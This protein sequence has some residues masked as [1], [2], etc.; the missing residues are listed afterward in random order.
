M[1]VGVVALA[2]GLTTLTHPAAADD[3]DDL[4]LDEL[5]D[6][7]EELEEEYDGEVPEFTNAKEEAEA[8]QEELDQV[9]EDLE[10]ARQRVSQLAAAQYRGSGLDPTMEL[11]VSSDPENVLEDA[12]VVGHM[13]HRESGLVLNLVDAK[14]E[15]EDAADTA[16]EALSA[17]E[18][19]IEDLESRRDEVAERIEELEAE[20]LPSGGGDGT[21]PE[22]VKGWGWDGATPRM[23]AARDEIIMELGT[24]YDVG[25]L[26]PGD[27]GDHG[28]GNACDW[29]M[30]VGGTMPTDENLAWG[31]AIADYAIENAD[32]L[33]IKYVIWKQRIY[34]T[35]TSGGW[36]QMGDRGSITENHWDHPHISVF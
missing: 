22:S 10:A 29:M 17:A 12:S 33:G 13:A 31:D 16:A 2:L 34:D 24:P 11:M 30:S 15:S 5:N 21:I 20:E 9:N 7:A 36:S 35:R 25:C 6:R 26:R 18:E 28:T 19:I 27:P 23:A 4:D 14:A 32:R 3:L 1:A 8:A